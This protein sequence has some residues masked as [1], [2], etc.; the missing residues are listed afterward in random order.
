MS[1]PRFWFTPAPGYDAPDAA[2]DGRRPAC[3]SRALPC[4]WRRFHAHPLTRFAE[5]CDAACL[6]DIL[7]DA[8]AALARSESGLSGKEVDEQRANL[9]QAVWLLQ[10]TPSLPA[11]SNRARALRRLYDTIAALDLAG[12]SES[13]LSGIEADEQRDNL[14]QVVRLLRFEAR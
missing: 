7:R 13:G 3:R 11:N 10:T 6:L 4:A 9:E 5:P 1:A 8:I 14:V 2:S 12:R